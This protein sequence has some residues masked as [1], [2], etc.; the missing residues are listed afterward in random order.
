KTNKRFTTTQILF[1]VIETAKALDYAHKRTA[2][3]GT[4]LNIVH[5]DVTPHNV[6]LAFNGDVKLM[7]FG[8]AK[9]ASRA[10]KTRA[11]TVKGK[12]AYMSPEQARG[13]PLDGRSDM[14]SLGIIMWELLSGRRLFAG[15]SD[16][17]V[18]SKVLKSEIQ[19]PRS[20]D[21]NVPEEVARICM[22]MLDRDR[23]SRYIDCGEAL[24]DLNAYLY[25]QCA[26]AHNHQLGYYVQCLSEVSG[27]SPDELPNYQPGASG[28]QDFEDEDLSG[29]ATQMLSLDEMQA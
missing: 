27:H 9:A 22:K 18:L 24:Q 2:P 5:R 25:G 7:D 15:G 12:C 20:I 16:F 14:F 6:M 4:P 3:D 17:D 29:E 1:M 26:D 11:G 28:G 8:I 13:K 23:D 21:S 10:T 19:N